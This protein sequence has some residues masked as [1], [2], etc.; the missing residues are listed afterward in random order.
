MNYRRSSGEKFF[1]AV[2]IAFLVVFAFICIYPFWYLLVISLNDGRDSARGGLYF[3][4]RVFSLENIKIILQW[5]VFFNSF[6]ISVSRIIVYVPLFL[7][8]T[9]LAA[10]AM[11]RKE[12]VA[13]NIIATYML[14]TMLFGGGLIPYYLVL[15]NL[16]L[17]N[18]FWVYIF[19]GLFSV[20]SMIVMRTSFY[21]IPESLLESARIDGASD[22]R[23]YSQFTIPLSLPMLATLALFGAVGQWNDWFAG[24]F[25][26]N[27][28]RLMPL[29]TFVQ[30]MLI[31]GGADDLRT[32]AARAQMDQASVGANAVRFTA[33]SLKYSAVL[34]ASIP[35]ILVYPFLQK[36]FVKGV[37]IGSIKG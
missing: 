7:F 35:I 12:F 2:I 16:G 17:T 21:S 27:E 37:M 36:Y 11:S 14:I 4:P 26:V 9:S 3:W 23:L 22:F 33:N 10:Y 29:Q 15:F 20:W 13:R 1:A 31:R 8:I 5:D 25:F 6:F 24:A 19:P 32:A 18:T 28:R 34:M 30:Y